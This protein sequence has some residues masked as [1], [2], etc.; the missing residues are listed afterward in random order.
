LALLVLCRR[1]RF[2][3]GM[4]GLPTRMFALCHKFHGKTLDISDTIGD[5]FGG[6]FKRR[7]A[8]RISSEIS[9]YF[10]ST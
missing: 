5:R 6:I 2:P 8:A 9:K 7:F 4:I 3:S 1:F 10:A